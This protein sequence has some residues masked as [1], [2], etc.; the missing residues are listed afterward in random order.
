MRPI[1]T[2][3]C[4]PAP[5]APSMTA[6]VAAISIVRN[7][8]CPPGCRLFVD[9]GAAV[10]APPPCRPVSVVSS[11]S[12]VEEYR[13]AIPLQTDV[14]PIGRVRAGVLAPGNQGLATIFR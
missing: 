12:Y 10:P 9:G 7:M 3:S 1:L 6:A 8:R 2:V 11:T 5:P 4:A 13:F 14:E